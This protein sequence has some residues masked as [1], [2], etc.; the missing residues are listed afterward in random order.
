MKTAVIGLKEFGFAE[1]MILS[2]SNIFRVLCILF[3]S[4]D[5]NAA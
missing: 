1:D 3:L 5:N 4:Y 2:N